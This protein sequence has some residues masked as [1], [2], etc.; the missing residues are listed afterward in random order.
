M[1][2]LLVYKIFHALLS[3]TI[4]G[5]SLFFESMESK[6]KEGKAVFNKITL[7]KKDSVDIW[8]MKQSHHGRDSI[9]WDNIE[10]HVDKS[11]S[12]HTV[13]Y[14][15][16]DSLGAEVDFKTSCFRCHPSG[17]R[18]IRPNGK[19]S[20]RERLKMAKMNALIKS[21]GDVV[22]VDKSSL[23][24]KTPFLEKLGSPLKV[25]SCTSCHYKGGPRGELTSAQKL[26]IKHLVKRGEMPPWP[27]RLN[28][29]ERG[30]LNKFIYGM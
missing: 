5:D 6:T 18:L 22:H 4:G 24:R 2:I 21:Y 15:Q 20:I 7:I 17:P 19:L 28:K 11:K 29:A 26:T 25:K 27:Y 23:V 14:F 13:S 1:N 3:L 30:Q 8:K 16:F 12:P 10:I 9:V